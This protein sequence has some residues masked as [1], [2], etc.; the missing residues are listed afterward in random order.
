MPVCVL[1]TSHNQW[2]CYFSL[3]KELCRC[4]YKDVKLWDYPR[5]LKWTQC[6]YKGIY[7]LKRDTPNQS[8]REIQRFY[9]HG[10][11]DGV[12]EA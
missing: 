5:L 4:D 9:A 2:I 10:F 12:R 11:K 8:Q 6:N 7:N 1:A 3:Q